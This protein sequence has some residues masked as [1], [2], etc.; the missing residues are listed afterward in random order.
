[1]LKNICTVQ[2]LMSCRKGDV[3]LKM[4]RMLVTKI[5]VHHILTSIKLLKAGRLTT[6]MIPLYTLKALLAKSFQ[7]MIPIIE[8]PVMILT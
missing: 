3:K 7:T 6:P 1:M 8:I 5:M 2:S 4:K